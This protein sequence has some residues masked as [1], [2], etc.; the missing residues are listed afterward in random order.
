M[1]LG[2]VNEGGYPSSAMVRIGDVINSETPNIYEQL[3]AGVTA[4][5]VLHGSANPIGGQN[6]LIK[7]REGASP[8]GL[9]F[10]GAIASI[11]FALGEIVKQS[12]GARG[13]N[14]F[15]QTR[16]GVETF[17]A[18]RFI[19][20]KQYLKKWDDY[21]TAVKSGASVVPPERDLELEALGE[22]LQGKRLIHCHSD[23]QDEILMLLRLMQGFGVQIG[24]FQHVL[25][26]YKVADE[27]AQAGV[28]GST[29]SDWW[30]YK[31]EVYDAIPYNGSLMHDRGVVVSFNSDS[32]DL[33]R[34]LYSEAAK[35]VK[36]G[37]TSGRRGP[38]IRHYQSRQTIAGGQPRRLARTGQGRRLR[39][40][41]EIAARFHH[42]LSSE[43]WIGGKK[44]FRSFPPARAHRSLGQGTAGV[45]GESQKTSASAGPSTG[46]AAAQQQ[47][48][49]IAL[50]QQ[51]QSDD[52]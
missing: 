42:R 45:A 1:I 47:F 30:A 41:V 12:N 6:C 15:P 26:G 36:Y 16:M 43:T 28:G 34:R 29:F 2:G 19:A 3:A 10:E 13:G 50:E 24:T 51:S 37:G 48:F 39:H 23:R 5:H 14:R 21:N 46:D 27:L 44:I 49:E 17:F 18:N 25:E 11:K 9:K 33:A 20:A 40:L 38:E 35:A 4:A 8:E 32:D 22:I 52:E 31:F 7:L